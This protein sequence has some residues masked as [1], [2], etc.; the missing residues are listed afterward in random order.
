MKK[1]N[2]LSFYFVIFLTVVSS[3]AA[4]GNSI[5]QFG[6]TWNFDKEYEI[7][8][9]INGDWYVV[10]AA[11][12]QSVSPAPTA[13][14]NGSVINPVAGIQ[15]Y[16]SRGSG[17]DEAIMAQ[18][19]LSFDPSQSLVSTISNSEEANCVGSNAANRWLDYKGHCGRGIMKTQAVLTCLEKAPAEA[20]FR[21]GYAGTTFKE[22]FPISAIDWNALPKMTSPGNT[23]NIT[24][25]LRAFERPFIDHQN[26][27]TL[28]YTHAS[29][30]FNGYGRDISTNVSLAALYTLLNEPKSDSLAIRLIQLGIDNFSVTQAG[31]SWPNDGGHSSGRKYPVVFAALML[32]NQIMKTAVSNSGSTYGED[33]QSFYVTAHPSPTTAWEENTDEDYDIFVPDT[34]GNYRT[35]SKSGFDFQGHG[36]GGKKRDFMDYTIKHEGMPEW[37]INH[38]S[39][40][41]IDGLDWDAP[42]RGANTP[43]QQGGFI[44]A[45]QVLGMKDLWNHDA[46]FD[47]M[48]RSVEI[49]DGIS[50]DFAD[51][52]WKTY[53]SKYGCTWK[54]NDPEDINSNGSLECSQCEFNCPTSTE[55]PT[56]AVEF[57]QSGVTVFMDRQHRLRVL[58]T[59]SHFSKL[60]I[61]NVLGV[62][63]IQI[64][65][66]PNDFTVDLSELSMGNYYY[67]LKNAH[68]TFI[69]TLVIL[70]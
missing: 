25:L 34:D 19:P 12:I 47:Y 6:I 10:G 13:T 2:L 26:N 24:E 36:S 22:S 41:L 18:F 39:N 33:G 42:Y 38:S 51:G 17:F 62:L 68:S 55:N 20:S 66:V 30:N 63:I 59:T 37:G 60:L 27:W 32:N 5:T 4:T 53:R 16:D 44:L 64:D 7:G 21:P 65:T 23:P 35:H 58:G 9:F 3:Y 29:D 28:Q 40:H 15:G 50:G 56:S 46:L 1:S 67:T 57:Q 52:M 49:S 43:A 61:F 69:G 54:R 70:E 45:A 14:R 11:V 48:D 8:Q 31:G